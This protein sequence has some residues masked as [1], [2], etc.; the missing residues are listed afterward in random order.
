MICTGLATFFKCLHNTV[1]YL[2]HCFNAFSVSFCD[3]TVI[4]EVLGFSFP[5][6][7]TSQYLLQVVI[8]MWAIHC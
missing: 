1:G 4:P 6:A 2:P 7:K 3:I 5:C 8:S